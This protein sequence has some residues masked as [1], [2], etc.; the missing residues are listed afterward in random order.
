MQKWS[1]TACFYVLK[2]KMSPCFCIFERKNA[3][4]R[5]CQ[6]YG[7]DCNHLYVIRHHLLFTLKRLCRQF[8]CQQ[9]HVQRYIRVL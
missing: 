5:H 7:S 9:S 1:I 8:T 6:C 2:H 4:Q 3:Q